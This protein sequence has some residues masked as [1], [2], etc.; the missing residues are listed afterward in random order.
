VPENH[1]KSIG[2][3]AQQI[4]LESRYMTYTVLVGL[5]SQHKKTKVIDTHVSFDFVINK[6]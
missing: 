2:D 1:R 5:K 4:K 6:I 3:V